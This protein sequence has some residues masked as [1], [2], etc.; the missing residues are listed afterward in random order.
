MSD[1]PKRQTDEGVRLSRL[2][3]TST[4]EP[5]RDV[6]QEYEARYEE[7]R[8]VK[9][10]PRSYS[11]INVSDEERQWAAIAHASIWFTILGGILTAGFVV[12]I[13]IFVPLVIYFMYRKKSDYVVFHALQ[14]FVVQ[15]IATVGV[16]ALAVFGGVIWV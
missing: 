6:V 13:S 11:T 7:P 16:L 2:S 14:A 10:M 3:G 15:L 9:A 4:T 1:D 5:E 8:K 12:P